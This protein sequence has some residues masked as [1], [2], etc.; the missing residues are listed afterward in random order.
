MATK[1]AKRSKEVN[2]KLTLVLGDALSPAAQTSAFVDSQELDGGGFTIKTRSPLIK[3]DKFPLD[4]VLKG[5]FTKLVPCICGKMEDG[6]DKWGN[7]IEI[8]P[9]G[10]KVGVAL[11]AT[12]VLRGALDITGVGEE[13]DSIHIGKVVAIQ[14]LPEKLPSK[15]GN[16][17]WNFIVGIQ[18]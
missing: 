11:A 12:A 4:K 2:R 6:K 1:N 16:D 14:R 8:V 13:A 18:D 15:K 17:A 10:A 5:V 7:L 9:V 3:P